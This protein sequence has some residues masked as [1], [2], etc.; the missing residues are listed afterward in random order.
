[1]KPLIGQRVLDLTQ[2]VAG[3]YCTQI[4]ADLG[5]EVIKIERPGSGDDTRQWTP[6]VAPGMSPT[7][8]TLNR[9]KQSLA[10]DLD[11]PEGQALVRQLLR[12]DDVLIHSLKPGSAERRGMGYEA[13]A[14][15]KPGLVYCAISAFGS[16]GPMAGLPGYD[17]LIQAY[18][19][20]MSVTGH[21]GA[22]PAR[23][24]VSLIDMGT[25]LW[26]AL[27]IVA[28][29]A[30]RKDT[31]RGARIDTSLLETGVA[32]MTNPIA[33]YSVSGKLPRRMGSATSMLAPY[34]AFSTADSHVFICCGNDRLF[35]KLTEALGKPALSSD[36]RFSVNA[37]RVTN[38]AALHDELE[39]LTRKY[40][41]SDVTQR[42][43]DAGVPVSPV[44]DLSHVLS[45]EQVASLGMHQSLAL[46]PGDENGRRVEACAVGLPVRFNGTRE[47]ASEL[48]LRPGQD[49]L[50]ILRAAGLSDDEIDRLA[51]A[52]VV[53]N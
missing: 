43:R 8:G 50:R 52:G 4:L 31:R 6:Q 7:Y 39:A 45:D 36:S 40:K 26:S 22:A 44:H 49:G 17:P 32:W 19:G 15:D 16:T 29:L 37:A 3:P 13:L 35:R 18:A 30:Q 10:I 51:S 33:N 42:L 24:G 25:G 11:H 20:I 23:V 21:E 12:N 34:E 9:G 5:A 1:M 47:F 41:T 48:T 38:R 46:E 53:G 27:A 2:N 28:A 14:V